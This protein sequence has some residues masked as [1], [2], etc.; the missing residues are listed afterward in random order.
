MTAG[1]IPDDLTVSDE[2]DDAINYE[3]EDES[4]EEEDEDW[5]EECEVESGTEEEEEIDDDGPIMWA[6]VGTKWR[7]PA[8]SNIPETKFKIA[9]RVLQVFV[10]IEPNSM[11]SS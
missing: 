5:E 3:E 4:N 8:A 10:T 11:N 2:E 1:H 9:S 7:A 6:R